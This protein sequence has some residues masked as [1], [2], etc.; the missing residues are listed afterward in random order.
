MPKADLRRD[1]LEGRADPVWA[2][3]VLIL[4]AACTPA[5]GTPATPT[6]SLPQTLS[7]ATPTTTPT[8]VPPITTGSTAGPSVLPEVDGRVGFVGCSVIQDS[9]RGYHDVGGTLLWNSDRFYGGGSVAAWMRGL[10]DVRSRYWSSFE[11]G[12]AE[13][14]ETEVI[15]W[16]LCTNRGQPSDSVENALIVLEEIRMRAPD[17]AIVVGSQ[18][19]YAAGH[20]CHISGADGPAKMQELAA[21]LV[22]QEGLI[23]GPPLG[24]LTEAQTRDGCHAN[25]EGMALLGNQLVE[26][27]GD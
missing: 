13:F 5:T 4:L 14:P 21:T 15:F 20:V 26:F 11:E 2:A 8:T 7:T 12:L 16:G 27:F 10:T 3:L 25:R 24:P 6:T 23:A 22:A 18:P 9:V 17:A 1:G 19:T